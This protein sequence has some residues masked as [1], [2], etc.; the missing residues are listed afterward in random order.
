MYRGMEIED[1]KDGRSMNRGGEA[2]AEAEAEEGIA[3]GILA[4]KWVTL[5]SPGHRIPSLD[6]HFN[7]QQASLARLKHP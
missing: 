2:E 4:R 6:T 7:S 1:W 5:P 3:V